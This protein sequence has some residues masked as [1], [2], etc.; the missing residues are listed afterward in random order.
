M[1]DQRGRRGGTARERRRDALRA[2]VAVQHGESL[3]ASRIDDENPSGIVSDVIFFA[4]PKVQAHGGSVCNVLFTDG[5]VRT[6]N[7]RQRR[8]R[9]AR[10][11][12][13]AEEIEA[14]VDKTVFEGIFQ[15]QE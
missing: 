11:G 5:E 4:E 1:A 15:A 6:F 7:D 10:H 3:G 2:Y 13:P 9:A 12:V 14:V 8:L